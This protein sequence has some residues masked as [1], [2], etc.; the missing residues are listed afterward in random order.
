[1]VVRGA[2]ELPNVEWGRSIIISGASSVA[3]GGASVAPDHGGFAKRRA[4][5]KAGA[6]FVGLPC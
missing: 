5:A 4:Y 1:M 6:S 2:E 3:F